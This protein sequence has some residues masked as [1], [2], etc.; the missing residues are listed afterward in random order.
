MRAFIKS[1]LHTAYVQCFKIYAHITFTNWVISCVC[2]TVA[3]SSEFQWSVRWSTRANVKCTRDFDSNYA[4]GTSA[5][6][7]CS[8]LR[9]PKVSFANI[10]FHFSLLFDA[11]RMIIER[12]QLERCHIIIW[13][14]CLLS[15]RTRVSDQLC[16]VSNETNEGKKRVVRL[17][18]PAIM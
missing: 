14:G 7:L 3:S 4:F 9:L 11:G 8:G 17:S 12:L 2:F 13:G 16:R 10:V 1:Q 6:R 15:E 5:R 18:P